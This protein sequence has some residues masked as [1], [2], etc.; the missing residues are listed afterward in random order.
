MPLFR[1]PAATISR[2]IGESRQD[3]TARHHQRSF[4]LRLERGVVLHFPDGAK[5]P[6]EVEVG[7][8]DLAGTELCLAQGSTSIPS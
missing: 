1:H 5:L 2:M 3:G 7:H 8:S 4:V 6:A